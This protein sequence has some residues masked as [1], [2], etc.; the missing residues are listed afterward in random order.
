MS[1]PANRSRMSPMNLNMV[2]GTVR[3]L[4]GK[5]KHLW[6]EA[7]SDDVTCLVDGLTDPCGST[8]EHGTRVLTLFPSLM[9][10][11]VTRKPVYARVAPDVW[12]GLD[13]GT[14]EGLKPGVW[15]KARLHPVSFVL[16]EALGLRLCP[17]L[18]PLAPE[19]LRQDRTLRHM[20][21][22]ALA[23]RESRRPL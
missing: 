12:D 2:S 19:D 6:N 14:R 13:A 9:P 23:R 18:A 16:E 1:Y 20:T 4:G 21:A 8:T 10:P 15:V 5:L 17:D 3:R 11:L 7:A 22:E